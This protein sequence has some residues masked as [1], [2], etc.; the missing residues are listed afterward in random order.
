MRLFFSVEKS[1]NTNFFIEKYNK[2]QTW[3]FCFISKKNVSR[4]RNYLIKTQLKAPLV[5]S[6][7]RFILPLLLEAQYKFKKQLTVNTLS[8][9][10][11][12]EN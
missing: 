12:D 5:F 10:P 8:P 1:D 3:S 7:H 9:E 4:Q 2:H 6:G 11:S